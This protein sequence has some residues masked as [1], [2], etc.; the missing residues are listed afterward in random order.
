MKQQDL[1]TM[2]GATPDSFNMAVRRGLSAARTER[3][4]NRKPLRVFALAAAALL[5]MMGAAYAA[6]PSQVAAWFGQSY[7]QETGNWLKEGK[8]DANVKTLDLGGAVFTLEE[9]VQRNHGLY[10]VGTV[11]LKEGSADVL[12]AE[13]QEVTEPF[14]YDI[15]GAGGRPE[16]APEGTPTLAET[17][18]KQGGRLLLATFRLDKVG[19]DGGEMLFPDCVGY[20]SIPQ[21]DGSLR[22]LFEVEDGVA[23]EEGET[24]RLSLWASIRELSGDGAVKKDTKVEKTWDVDIAPKPIRQ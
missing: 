22:I 19:V 3:T 18:Q 6:F 10:G 21:R 14:G 24:Y 4:G 13:D 23:V 8:A 12:V 11:T 1:Q 9:V 20:E 16:T 17:A 5:V 15:H 2:Y 7:G